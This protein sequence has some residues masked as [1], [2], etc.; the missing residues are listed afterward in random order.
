MK[1]LI[2]KIWPFVRIRINDKKVLVLSKRK[3]THDLL[4]MLQENSLYV[5]CRKEFA[6]VFLDEEGLVV[7][8]ES[9]M[10]AAV[11]GVKTRNLMLGYKVK[12]YAPAPFNPDF[13]LRVGYDSSKEK[14]VIFQSNKRLA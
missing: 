14:F 4:A 5:R 9:E 2:F 10:L 7:Y 6:T 1:Y 11:W 13:I 8:Y 12:A 3:L